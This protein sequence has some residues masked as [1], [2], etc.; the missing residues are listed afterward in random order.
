MI[1]GPQAIIALVII[2]LLFGGSQLPKLAKGLG[3]A[4]KEYKDASKNDDD[5]S[6][7]DPERP[8]S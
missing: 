8:P 1:G 4:Q 2:L 3:K 5:P 7:S 6:V